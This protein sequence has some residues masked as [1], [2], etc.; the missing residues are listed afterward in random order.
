MQPSVGVVE[1][2]V[3]CFSLRS[4]CLIVF[5]A[6]PDGLSDFGYTTSVME[7]GQ[8][9]HPFAALLLRSCSVSFRLIQTY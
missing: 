7:M 1:A 3:M 2:A 4:T 6:L 5:C 9:L 8:L